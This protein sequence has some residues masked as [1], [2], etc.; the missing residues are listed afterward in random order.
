ML[1]GQLMLDLYHNS[2]DYFKVAFVKELSLLRGNG[3]DPEGETDDRLFDLCP[4]KGNSHLPEP[5]E[6]GHM[7][8]GN[9]K[10]YI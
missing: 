3:Y 9:A 10:G 7:G 5:L 2:F 4:K 1:T 6:Y 8:G